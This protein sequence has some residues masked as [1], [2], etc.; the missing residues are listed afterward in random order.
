MKGRYLYHSLVTHLVVY[1][2]QLFLFMVPRVLEF[3]GQP[4]STY[5]SKRFYCRKVGIEP[6]MRL[7]Y[8]CSLVFETLCNILT[9]HQRL[10][11]L[12]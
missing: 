7:P 3:D 6:E 2:I 10:N 9:F 8:A 12:L 5:H 4:K 1:R 11:F